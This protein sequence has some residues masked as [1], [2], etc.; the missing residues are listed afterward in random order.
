MNNLIKEGFKVFLEKNDPYTYQIVKGVEWN[1]YFDL[2]DLLDSLV[3]VPDIE[4]LRVALEE[5]R[6][7]FAAIGGKL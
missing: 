2:R 4:E 3:D 1:S 6:I 5:Q 7:K